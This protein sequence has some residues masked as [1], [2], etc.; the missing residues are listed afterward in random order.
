MTVRA[1]F[2][3]A[4]VAALVFLFAVTLY[5]APA[6]GIV[7]E[8]GGQS[9]A[10]GAIVILGIQVLVVLMLASR[11]NKYVAERVDQ[12][13]LD[14]NSAFSKHR[15]DAY[16]HEPLRRQLMSDLKQDFEKLRGE[17]AVMEKHH[18]DDIKNL[19]EVMKPLIENNRVAMEIMATQMRRK[20]MTAEEEAAVR[21]G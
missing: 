19:T 17:L 5:A 8:V 16:A 20:P 10:I 4:L 21:G 12:R 1:W 15:L 11:L 3:A 6:V 13:M 14:D 18:H 7:S 2:V 9:F